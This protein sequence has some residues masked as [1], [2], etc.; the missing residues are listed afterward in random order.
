MEKNIFKNTT[1][2][3][4]QGNIGLGHAIAYFLSKR[5][6]VLEPLTENQPYDLVVDSKKGLKKKIQ[7]KTSNFKVGKSKNIWQIGLS[8]SGGNTKKNTVKYFDFTLVD[9]VFV[10]LSN[11]AMYNVPSEKLKNNKN[12]FN[13]DPIKYD[14]YRVF[15][16]LEDFAVVSQ[17]KHN[18]RIDYYESKIQMLEEQLETFRKESKKALTKERYT[19]L[20]NNRKVER[21]SYAQ[22]KEELKSS[23]FVD[24]GKKYGVCDN[25]IRHWM[26]MYEKYGKDF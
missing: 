20:K 13:L 19:F 15:L 9:F 7:V 3:T 5:Y 8:T 14:E 26:K 12:C 11:G 6:V 4:E 18:E 10:V 23:T 21:P 25:S 22:L 17:Q 2:N 16:Q 1:T 24:V